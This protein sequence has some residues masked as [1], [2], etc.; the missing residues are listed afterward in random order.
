MQLVGLPYLLGGQHEPDVPCTTNPDNL[1]VT[2]TIPTSLTIPLP[3]TVIYHRF[4]GGD[5]LP[6]APWHFFFIRRQNHSKQQTCELLVNSEIQSTTEN[7]PARM[8]SSKPACPPK[9]L[10][11]GR[12]DEVQ[13]LGPRKSNE[14]K[15]MDTAMSQNS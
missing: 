13:P 4:L 11:K 10:A 15:I 8:F 7:V 12:E 9:P 1:R 14:R 2:Y 3:H 6:P 5:F